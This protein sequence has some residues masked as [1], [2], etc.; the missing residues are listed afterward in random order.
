MWKYR[1]CGHFPFAP[2]LVQWLEIHV[3]REVVDEPLWLLV[4]GSVEEEEAMPAFLCCHM[5]HT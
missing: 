5:P 3:V 2:V 4:L 1:K